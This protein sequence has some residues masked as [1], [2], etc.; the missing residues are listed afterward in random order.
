MKGPD[1]LT[2][3]DCAVEKDDIIEHY[4][5]AS[6]VILAAVCR[7]GGSRGSAAR[8]QSRHKSFLLILRLL[9][10]ISSTHIILGMDSV[11]RVTK[12]AG[13]EHYEESLQVRFLVI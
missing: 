5:D 6:M 3:I 13:E 2:E 10:F 1:A 8:I 11:S 12:F 7:E 4:G 9:P